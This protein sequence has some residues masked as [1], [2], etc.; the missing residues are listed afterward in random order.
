VSA[1]G[2]Q[3]RYIRFLD[4]PEKVIVFAKDYGLFFRPLPGLDV[5]K[6]V[7]KLHKAPDGAARKY[8]LD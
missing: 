4:G 2:E 6:E 3:I 7:A 8:G 5:L 1:T